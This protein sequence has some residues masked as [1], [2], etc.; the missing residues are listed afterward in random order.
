MALSMGKPTVIRSPEQA[1]RIHEAVAK[2]TKLDESRFVWS[3]KTPVNELLAR[4]KQET[5]QKTVVSRNLIQH[6][7]WILSQVSYEELSTISSQFCGHSDLD[8][9]FSKECIHFEEGLFVKTYKLTSVDDPQTIWGLASLCNHSISFEY[10]QRK[11]HIPEEKFGLD[12]YPAVK[13]ERFAIANGVQ[14]EGVGT[15]FLQLLKGLFVFENR[16]GCRFLVVDS[17]VDAVPFYLKN[18]FELIDTPVTSRL[19]EL[20]PDC[21]TVQLFFNLLNS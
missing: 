17:L 20:D 16:T 15:V 8:H 2:G 7:N 6:D 4:L 13:I 12:S 10:H 14:R 18:D 3:T 19:E 1:K 9:F 11:T 5:R 21:D